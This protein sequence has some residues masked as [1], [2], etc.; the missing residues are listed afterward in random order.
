V[1]L[2]LVIFGLKIDRKYFGKKPKNSN[3]LLDLSPL[4]AIDI[5]FGEIEM[6]NFYG[7]G[8]FMPYDVVQ[9]RSHPR[10]HSL[11]DNLFVFNYKDCLKL[12]LGDKIETESGDSCTIFGYTF[13]ENWE[14]I[15]IKVIDESNSR[16]TFAIVKNNKVMESILLPPVGIVTD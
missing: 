2:P 9:M 5:A 13:P 12:K 6:T 14:E 16:F 8:S 1:P 11:E 7:E 3:P 4:M 15:G 10:E